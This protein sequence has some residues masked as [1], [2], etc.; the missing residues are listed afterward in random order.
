MGYSFLED[1]KVDKPLR[2]ARYVKLKRKT[3]H[4]ADV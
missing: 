3:N 4:S 2:Q 1:V